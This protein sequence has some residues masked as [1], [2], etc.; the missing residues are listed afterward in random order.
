M[1]VLRAAILSAVV[2]LPSVALAETWEIDP[3]HSN[4]GFSVKHLMVSTVRGDFHKAQGTVVWDEKAPAKSAINVTIDAA[5]LDTREPKRDE[6]LRSADF[7]DVQNHPTLTFASTKVER[8]GKGKLKVTGNLTMHGVT[9]PM[10]L[11]VT[12]PTAA[13]KNPYGKMVMAASAVGKLNRKD[14]G[15]TWNKTM[16]GGGVIVG[17]EVG[18]TIDVELIKK[19][20]P[21]EATR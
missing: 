17:D 10:V 6:H 18:L 1:N 21:A 19:E 5:S 8:D 14:F 2:A 20:G 3:A 12:G 13:V 9:R 4:V 11:Q 15:L 16:D 7:F